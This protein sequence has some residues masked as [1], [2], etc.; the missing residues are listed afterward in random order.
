MELNKYELF[1]NGIYAEYLTNPNEIRA[2]IRKLWPVSTKFELVRYGDQNDGGYL[3]PNDLDDIAACY[4][5]GVDYNASFELDILNRKGIGSHLIDY[6]VE[7]PPSGFSCLSFTKKFIG[8]YNSNIYITFDD[9]VKGTPEFNSYQDLLLQMDIEGAEYSAILNTSNH[10]LDRFRIIS[11]EIHNIEGWGQNNFFN[12]VKDFFERLLTK[13]WV[14]HNHPNNCCGVVNLAGVNLPRVF[15]LT[16][17]RKDRSEAVKYQNSFPHFLDNANI[18]SIPD[19]VLPSEWHWN[20]QQFQNSEIDSQWLPE[21]TGVIHVGANTGQERDIYDIWGINVVW[22]EALP[23]I[24]DVLVDNIRFYPLQSAY[25]LLLTDKEAQNVEFNYSNNNG[26]SSSIFELKHH[27]ALWP[28]INYVKKVNLVTDTFDSFVLRE[29]IDISK[30]NVL[31]LDTQG[32]ELLVLKGA[33]LQ[34]K[35]FKYIKIEVPDF[36]SYENCCTLDEVSAYLSAYGF[37]E[38]S[39]EVFREDPKVGKYYNVLFS[40]S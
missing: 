26:E 15:E 28:D 16:L 32:S 6:S 30:Y 5:P 34:L 11:I 7:G 13:Y 39:R 2:L 36:E 33:Q 31:V 25:N 23:D 17:L 37:S 22:I 29:F 24:Y 4:S 10:V 21:A 38:V 40:L 3:L 18:S 14:V 27:N 9:W 12:I 1:K 8:T 19:L 20:P 35:H